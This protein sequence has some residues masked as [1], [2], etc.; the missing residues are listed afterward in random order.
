MIRPVKP[1]ESDDTLKIINEAARAY[2]DVIP[3]DRWKDPYMLPEELEEEIGSGVEFFGYEVGQELVGV[4]GIQ[5]VEDTTL[6]RH[7][8]VL[9]DY[10]RKGIGGKLLQHL[11]N[12]AQTPEVLV[13]TWKAA[14][15]AIRFYRKY[16]FSLVSEEEKDRLLRKYWNIPQRQVETS[17]V[18][19]LKKND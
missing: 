16:G 6:I 13:G 4:A 9:S 8:Y 11:I 5:P 7:T 15:W 17:V 18:L 12:L 10:Q 19:K 2:K 3:Q 14:Y 1:G